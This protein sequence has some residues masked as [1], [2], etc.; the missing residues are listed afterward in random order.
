[1]NSLSVM[2][3]IKNDQYLKAWTE[4]IQLWRLSDTMMLELQKVTIIRQLL[5]ST[6]AF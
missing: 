3:A 2:I 5:E 6:Q 1:M 4:I